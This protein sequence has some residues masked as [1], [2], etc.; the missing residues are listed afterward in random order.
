MDEFLSAHGG[1][2][3]ELQRQLGLLRDNAFRAGSRALLFVG[4]AWA[5]PLILSFSEGHA[6]GNIAERPFLLD[7]GPSARFLIAIGLFMLMEFQVERKLRLHLNQFFRAPLIAPS[8]SNQAASAI[9]NALKR[10]DLPVAELMCVVIAC[11]LTVLSYPGVMQVGFASWRIRLAEN[12]PHLTLA[13]WWCLLVSAPIFFF[14]FFRWLW[15]HHVWGLLLRDMAKLELRLTASHPDGSG[16]LRFIGQYPNVY[17]VFVFAI[18]C[19]VAA[20]VANQLLHETLSLAVYSS[21]MGIWLAIVLALFAWPLLAFVGPLSK[22]KQETTLIASSQATNRARATEREIIGQNVSGSDAALNEVKSAD[23]ADPTKLYEAGRKLSTLL[24]DR[25]ALVP[26]AA[27]ALIP[28][29]AAGA[30]QLPTKELIKV[31]KNLLL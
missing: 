24:V 28:L 18:S 6:F 3:Y 17:S 19:V 9:S 22:L 30:T 20:A 29:I 23:I 11:V 2:F 5:I 26:V 7:P 1:P 25:D 13:G 31:A 15:R 4:I 21:V 8:S 27:A 14:L 12:G 16:G 10:R